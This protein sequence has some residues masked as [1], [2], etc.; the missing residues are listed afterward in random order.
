MLDSF[1]LESVIKKIGGKE[2]K[3]KVLCIAMN[4]ASTETPVFG[5]IQACT[6]L[7]QSLFIHGHYAEQKLVTDI[8]APVIRKTVIDALDWLAEGMDDG[9][10]MLLILA[11]KGSLELS[12]GSTF[13]EFNE[14]VDIAPLG[15]TLFILSGV[16]LPLESRFM[17]KDVSAACTQSIQ[18][19][20]KKIPKLVS[21]AETKRF[22]EM[23]KHETC[24]SVIC[25]YCGEPTTGH[26]AFLLDYLLR[27]VYT[28]SITLQTFLQYAQ[29]CLVVNGIDGECSL[30]SGQFMDLQVP[31]GRLLHMP[32]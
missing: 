15:T 8:H 29:A 24:S 16:Y 6:S 18:L 12:D 26:L 28:Y 2:I 25:I 32:I 23:S 10:I 19:G 20:S 21:K 13:S 11:G 30:E 9:D 14:F 27:N 31:L 22:E 1:G 4:Y 17:C 7:M 5:N 3:K